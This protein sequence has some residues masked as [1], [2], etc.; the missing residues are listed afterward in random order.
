VLAFPNTATPYA[1]AK[2]FSVIP[3]QAGIKSS[4]IWT[5][6]FAQVTVSGRGILSKLTRLSSKWVT[7]R[8]HESAQRLVRGCP[9]Q[10]NSAMDP[11][12]MLK[13]TIS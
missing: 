5:P 9:A 1:A 12:V 7:A 10:T 6:A 11:R 2:A 4:Q 3:A 8:A 13:Y